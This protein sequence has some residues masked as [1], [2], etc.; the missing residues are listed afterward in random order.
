VDR[1]TYLVVDPCNAKGHGSGK[2]IVA[3]DSVGA[4]FDEVVLLAQGSSARQTQLSDKKAVDAVI[5]GIVDTV[6]EARKVTYRK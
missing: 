6:E 1:P 5:V 4:G 2:H 3:L